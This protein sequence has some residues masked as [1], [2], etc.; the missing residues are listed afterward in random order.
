MREVICK[1]CCDWLMA[2][3]S[4]P[5]SWPPG[6]ADNVHGLASHLKDAAKSRCFLYE[7]HWSLAYLMYT[8]CYSLFRLCDSPLGSRSLG[9]R[10][11][12]LVK[13]I[14]AQVSSIYDV[15]DFSP[16]FS[17]FR[18]IG[19]WQNMSMISRSVWCTE[20]CSSFIP[21]PAWCHLLLPGGDQSTPLVIW[22]G[23]RS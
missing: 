22:S 13:V 14:W 23:A 21:S 12:N 10:S 11:F 7:V 5:L 3:W 1:A 20:M 8:S 6:D 15:K 4:G 16:K 2:V 9:L 19:E 18:L 17:A